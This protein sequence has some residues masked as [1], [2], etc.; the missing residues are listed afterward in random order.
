MYLSLQNRALV[1]AKLREGKEE[2]AAK[3]TTEWQSDRA[4]EY[5]EVPIAQKKLI[6]EKAHI[7]AVVSKNESA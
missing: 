7:D 1:A 4:V 3:I 5:P 2:E 6:D